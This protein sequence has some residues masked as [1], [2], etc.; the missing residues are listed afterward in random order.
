MNTEEL[1]RRTSFI[2]LGARARARALLDA[3]SMR[4]LIGPFERLASPWLAQQGVVTQADDGVVVAKGRIDGEPAA[5]GACA[6]P[7]RAPG[8]AGDG[9]VGV[10]RDERRGAQPISKTMA[11]P[12]AA[13]A[14]TTRRAPS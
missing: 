11:H 6:S 1:L 8:V 10:D 3:G 4:E 7:G 14:G 2:E 13:L 9:R 5:G 12:S